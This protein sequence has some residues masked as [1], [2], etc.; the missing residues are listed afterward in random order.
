MKKKLHEAF[1]SKNLEKFKMLLERPIKKS[2]SKL[3]QEESEEKNKG[4][5]NAFFHFNLIR[6][7]SVQMHSEVEVTNNNHRNK[8]ADLLSQ[9]IL[10]Y[11]KT[12]KDMSL[13]EK[14]MCESGSQKFIAF[15]WSECDFWRDAASL[16]IVELLIA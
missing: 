13:L 16:S 12:S 15:V 2:L 1:T 3:K 6:N 10:M 5:S 14:I 7:F 8:F 11:R 9:N 4:K